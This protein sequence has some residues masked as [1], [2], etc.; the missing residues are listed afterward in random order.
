MDK[1]IDMRNGAFGIS[2]LGDAQQNRIDGQEERESELCATQFS[3]KPENCR[4]MKKLAVL[5][6][7]RV[8]LKSWSQISTCFP[9][10]NVNGCGG[11]CGG[12]GW[13]VWSCVRLWLGPEVLA[14]QYHLNRHCVV[15][16]IALLPLVVQPQGSSYCF[17]L[18][19][20]CPK[21]RAIHLPPAS[22]L[23]I[24]WLT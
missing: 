2:W 7:K 13:L 14:Q 19:L 6:R 9:R 4:P 3:R 24:R 10:H 18:C 12:G 20:V 23:S 16:P 21:Q 15:Y 8:Q 5:F 11:Y 1:Q 22:D 17:Y